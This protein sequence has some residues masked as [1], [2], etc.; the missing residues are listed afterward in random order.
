MMVLMSSGLIVNGSMTLTE[1]RSV[2]RVRSV[3]FGR[4][5]LSAMKGTL[6]FLFDEGVTSA[7]AESS[8]MKV[9][10]SANLLIFANFICCNMQI[11]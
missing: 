4:R 6:C 3:K 2:G 11:N 9:R 7:Y 1:I 5:I 8:N 10:T